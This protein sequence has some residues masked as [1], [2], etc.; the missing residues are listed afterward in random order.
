[1]RNSNWPGYGVQIMGK[2][3][4]DARM[5]VDVILHRAIPMSFQIKN[6]LGFPLCGLGIQIISRGDQSYPITYV[7]DRR[8][9]A[10]AQS[11]F[12][13]GGRYQVTVLS[14]GVPL[15]TENFVAG[16]SD[17]LEFRIPMVRSASLTPR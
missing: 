3:G 17:P 1:M 4:S 14:G 13:E 5:E 10:Q 8:G 6:R 16:N 15:H 2:L 7:T 9:I 11:I 12:R